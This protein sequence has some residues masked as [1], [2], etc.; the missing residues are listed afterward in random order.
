MVKNINSISD[1]K[2]VKAN[3]EKYVGRDNAK[4]EL[5]NKPD[6][7]YKITVDGKAIHIGST[8]PDFTKHGSESRRNRY[9]KR[10]TAIRGDWK[11]DKYSKNNLAVNLLWK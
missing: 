1:P 5:S 11:K 10:A 8:M 6:K 2:K 3:F 9:L 7:K 4:L